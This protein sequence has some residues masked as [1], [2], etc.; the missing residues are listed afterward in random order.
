MPLRSS[1]LS[2]VIPGNSSE[3]RG[4]SGTNTP[5]QGGGTSAFAGRPVKGWL[6]LEI[7]SGESR[8]QNGSAS[9]PESTFERASGSLFA[10]ASI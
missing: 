3:A 9:L 2:L 8:Y 6:R 10:F 1:C 4:V 5:G 7:V